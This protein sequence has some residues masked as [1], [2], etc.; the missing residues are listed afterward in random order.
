M[1][2]LQ[3]TPIDIPLYGLVLAGGKSSR[4]GRDKAA[5]IYHGKPQVQVGYELLEKFCAKVF[6]STRAEQAKENTFVGLNQIHDSFLNMGPLGGIL[7]AF[8]AHRQAAW[9]I[10]ACDLPF[11]N[12]EAIAHLLQQRD[13]QKFA[14]A[15][16]STE[17]GLPEPL[18]AIYEPQSYPR[19]LQFLGEGLQCPR[20]FLIRSE[21][22]QVEQQ[23][24]H[25][26]NV[27]RPEELV[28]AM[29]VLRGG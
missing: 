4:M 12:E 18:C 28:E 2:N 13:I 25:L 14:T 27:N 23:G 26:Q 5:L 21:I 10:L 20:K 1:S 22:V 9:L 19:L 3:D 7:S 11:V 17:D 6:V 24:A 29:R 15:Y 8:R 16:I